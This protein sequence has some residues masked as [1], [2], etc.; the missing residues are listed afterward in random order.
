MEVPKREQVQTR[1]LTLAR[2]PAIL[3]FLVLLVVLVI[4]CGIVIR[5]EW[6]DRYFLRSYTSFVASLSGSL[7]E[8]LGISVRV[9]QTRIL[10]ETFSV[11]IR[12]G[13]DGLEAALLLFCATLAY[14]FSLLRTRLFAL[15]SGYLLIFVLN[16]I[17]VVGLFM[18]GLR[19]PEAVD[20]MHN[21]VA[22]FAI[23][24]LTTV[25]WLYWIARDKA[26][27]S[28]GTPGPAAV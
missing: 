14:P 9:E 21:Y 12:K 18:V 4:I 11:E 6:F 10:S 5:T 15:A 28:G 2:N 27:G 20:F 19:W 24:T 1:Q 23:I 25:F 22:Q 8:M 3:R 7:L 16:L 13:C 17:R 26:I